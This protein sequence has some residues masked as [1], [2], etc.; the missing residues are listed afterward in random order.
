[1][2]A[3]QE[4][5]LAWKTAPT[6]PAKSVLS[7]Y[8]DADW[9]TRLFLA[10]RWQVTPYAGMAARFPEAGEILDLACGHGLLSLSLATASPRRNVIGIDHDAPRIAIAEHA[11]R[12]VP[13]V[14]FRSG[15]FSALDEPRA[16]DAIGIIDTMHYFT[17][18]MQEEIFRKVFARVRPGGSFI[19]RE[20]DPSNAGVASLVNRLHE[21]FMVGLGF[22]KAE[23]LHFRSVAGWTEAVTRA[24]FQVTSQ[25]F[26]RFP[27]A[28]VLFTCLRP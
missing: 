5:A 17:Y 16:W 4:S 27:Y 1:M 20:V 26:A 14:Q 9:R 15:D 8:R 13:N 22:T 24:G 11:A 12:G 6:A 2:A 28:D 3:Q 19:F 21:K 7:L 18:A 23:E 10:L 25:P